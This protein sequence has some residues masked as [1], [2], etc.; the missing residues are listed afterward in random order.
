MPAKIS[1]EAGVKI[2]WD[3]GIVSTSGIVST[4]AQSFQFKGAPAFTAS[5][6]CERENANAACTPILPIRM[7][8]SA[9][10][11]RKFAEKILLKS[12]KGS[13]KPELPKENGE[14]LITYL[15]FKPPFAEKSELSIEL[16]SG[17]KDDSGRSLSN[18]AQFPFKLM[19]ADFPAGEIPGGA[20]RH[21]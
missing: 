14:D 8:F 12:A 16:P 5:V 17:L 18:A 11:Q 15:S 1:A 2:V 6:S 9:G 19:T 13:V 7:N 20:V 21:R 3:K 10:I 4:R